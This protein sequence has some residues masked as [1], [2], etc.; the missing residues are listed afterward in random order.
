LY[1]TLDKY[2]LE[3]WEGH[4]VSLPPVK[5]GLKVF[6]KIIKKTKNVLLKN[7]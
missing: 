7:D 3:R 5:Q 1:G 6:K 2:P 4:R